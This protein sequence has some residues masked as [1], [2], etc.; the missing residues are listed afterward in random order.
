[1]KN[2]KPIIV[3]DSGIG[4]LS[5]YRPLKSALPKSKII[6]LM[7]SPNFPYGDKSESWLLSRFKELAIEFNAYD[8]A[9][10][11]LAC[12]T[13]TTNV[14]TQLRRDLKCP[15]IGVEPVIKPLAKYDRALALMTSSSRDSST[16]KMLL[17][18]YGAHVQIYCPAGLASA[19]ENNDIEQMK[20][21]IHEIKE[22]VQRNNIQV[23]GLSCTHYPLILGEFKKSIKDVEF[24]DPA[25]S[26]VR[27]VLRVLES[28]GYG[29]F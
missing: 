16:T 8:P 15:V 1:M 28:S 7:D 4:G 23:I 21:S 26:V 14:I 3:F 9:A 17:E 27:E 13:A 24:Y 11:V 22:I 10:L 18:K 12:N 5:I 29:Q 2:S 25:L 19:I 20:T 6:Y